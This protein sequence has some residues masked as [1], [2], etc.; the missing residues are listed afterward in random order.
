MTTSAPAPFTKH[1]AAF[2]ELQYGLG[3]GSGKFP[4]E[5]VEFKDLDT[6][7]WAQMAKDAGMKYAVLTAKH[8]DGFCLWPSNFTEYC[9]KNSPG[10]PDIMAQYVEAFRKAGLKTGIYYSLWDRNYPYYNNDDVY[11]EYMRNQITELLTNYGEIISI[12]FDGN[13]DKDHP[14]REWPYDPNWEKD[15]SYPLPRGERWQWRELYDLVHKLQPGCLTAINS[16]S[17]C[18]GQ[19]MYPPTD[20][21]SCEHLDFIFKGKRMELRTDPYFPDIDGSIVKIPL[22]INTTLPPNWFFIE[23]QDYLHPTIDTICGYYRT[24]RELGANFL[25]NVGPDNNGLIPEY[26]R[27]FLNGAASRLG[28]K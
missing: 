22:E 18:L 13:W 16:G 28:L 3:W 14:T 4:A 15:P 27:Y 7:Q 20:Y 25:L 9:V 6:Y 19:V 1:Q 12:W 8:H 11:A 23:G 2:L 24:A 17:D 26:H 5:K 21:R 10:K